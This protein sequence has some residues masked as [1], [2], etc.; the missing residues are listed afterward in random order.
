MHAATAVEADPDDPI[1]GLL[2]K[3]AAERLRRRGLRPSAVEA[4]IAYG[5]VVHIRGAEV[6]AIGRRE[7]EL[8]EREGVALAQYEGVQ[9][10]R[11]HDGIVLTVYRNRDFRGLRPRRR[12]RHNRHHYR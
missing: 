6:H 11:A 7:V 1:H 8:W 5:R 9:V 4:A 12:H 10:V 2:T 3:H